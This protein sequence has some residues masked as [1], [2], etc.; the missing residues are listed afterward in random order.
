MRS[1]R[2]YSR[3]CT[4]LSLEPLEDRQLPSTGLLASA[5]AH[6][7][8]NLPDATSSMAAE[9]LSP[10]ATSTP[11]AS[12]VFAPSVPASQSLTSAPTPITTLSAA[13]G[14]STGVLANSSA[15]QAVRTDAI[16]AA[17]RPGTGTQA[18]SASAN[19]AAGATAPVG[20]TAAAVTRPGTGT[21]PTT[22]A[23]LQALAQTPDSFPVVEVAGDLVVSPTARVAVGVP[24]LVVGTPA[25]LNGGMEGA[26]LT[27]VQPKPL[28]M[29]SVRQNA[30]PAGKV[31]QTVIESPA[32]STAALSPEAIDRTIS[33]L[34]NK[35]EASL[36]SLLWDLNL[37]VQPSDRSHLSQPEVS[38]S[39]AIHAVP[40]PVR[41][42]SQ[43]SPANWTNLTIWLLTVVSIGFES[44]SAPDRRSR[45]LDRP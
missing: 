5:L 28:P 21:T 39:R 6:A 19:P 4:R 22:V 1:T 35:S 37:A 10:N 23:A 16:F 12:I 43:K 45:G 11:T 7:V 42:D 18:Q 44:R 26:G 2:T 32:N 20:Q 27:D 34:V 9:T 30:K 15:A 36:T 17:E 24:A 31:A 33:E 41:R 13:G 25:Q 29:P 40:K 38:P 14:T 3:H 8:T